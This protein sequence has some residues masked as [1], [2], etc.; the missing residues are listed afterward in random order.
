MSIRDWK[1]RVTIATIAIVRAHHTNKFATT[2][3]SYAIIAL[4]T[5]RVS[6]G[7]PKLS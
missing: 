3:K 2:R 5:P 6:D 1:A 4:I 7:S